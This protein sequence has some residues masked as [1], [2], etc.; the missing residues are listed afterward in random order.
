MECPCAFSRFYSGCT[1]TIS[2]ANTMD[3]ILVQLYEDVDGRTR[4]ILKRISHGI[5]YDSRL[6][7]LT[8]LS[9]QLPALYVFFALSQAPPAFAIVTASTD[10]VT[11]LPASGPD[12][13][14]GPRRSPTATGMMTATMAGAT[15]SLLGRNGTHIHAGPVVPAPAFP[16]ISPFISLNCLRTSTTMDWAA[17][18]TRLHGKG[19]KQERQHASDKK[20]NGRR[21]IGDGQVHAQGR[22]NL[23]H[24]INIGRYQGQGP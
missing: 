24:L 14:S 16:S 18:P 4:G 10:P 9:S 5:A 2:P 15:I 17:S 8:A 22:V 21:R 19:R 6:V 1:A 12:P 23:L 20:A 11:V 7:F 3:T 13:P